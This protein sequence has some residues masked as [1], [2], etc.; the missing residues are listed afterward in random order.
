MNNVHCHACVVLCVVVLVW[1]V[2]GDQELSVVTQISRTKS[3]HLVS[4]GVVDLPLPCL[5]F[6]SLLA[7]PMITVTS[8]F[9]YNV[10]N[11]NCPFEYDLIYHNITTIEGMAI[12][13]SYNTTISLFKW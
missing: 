3:K 6:T 7:H 9:Q 2:S 13:R 11:F 5:Y 10:A 4:Q 12:C 8:V 1:E